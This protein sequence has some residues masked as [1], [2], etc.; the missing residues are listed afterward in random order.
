MCK[1]YFLNQSFRTSNII[2]DIYT[3][4][5]QTQQGYNSFLLTSIQFQ[6]AYNNY[7]WTFYPGLIPAVQ[8]SSNKPLFYIETTNHSYSDYYC[9]DN[10][11]SSSQCQNTFQKLNPNINWKLLVLLSS[12]FQPSLS[13]I[14]DYNIS[15]SKVYTTTGLSNINVAANISNPSS[16]YIATPIQLTSSFLIFLEFI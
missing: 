10:S 16:F 15:F 8:I 11:L 12:Y 4:K 7:L 14:F 13:R 2:T 9:N 1:D 5:V 3:A 6:D